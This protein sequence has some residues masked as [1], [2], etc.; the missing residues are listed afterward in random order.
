MVCNSVNLIG[1]RKLS[2]IVSLK[3]RKMVNQL[4]ANS[5]EK[6]VG[7]ISILTGVKYSLIVVQL[8]KDISKFIGKFIRDKFT[9][10]TLFIIVVRHKDAMFPL[11]N[12][13]SIY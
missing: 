6:L 9:R 2:E 4:S 7:T 10:N 13:L 3:L 8:N 12:R 11:L 1:Q 5:D